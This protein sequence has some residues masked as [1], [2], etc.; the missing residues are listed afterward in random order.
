[1]LACVLSCA[2]SCGGG[3]GAN[4]GSGTTTQPVSTTPALSLSSSTAG[5]SAVAGSANPTPQSIS[6]S[7]GGTGSLTGL[8][9]GTIVYGPGQVGGWLAATLSG[10]TA[11]ATL[12]LTP[13]VS[14]LPVGSYSA[15]IPISSSAAGVINS[16][17]VVSATLTVAAGAA[18]RLVFTTQ[19]AAPTGG[20]ISPA[21]TVAIEDAVGNVV[22]NATPNVTVTAAAN[23]SGATLGGTTTVAAVAGVA[24][25]G[26]LTVS[27]TATGLTLVASVPGLPSATSAAFNVTV[28]AATSISLAAAGQS[29]SFLTSPNF[30][31]ALSVQA[32]SQYLIAVVNTDTSYAQTEGF[33]LAGSPASSVA[34]ARG[35]IASV[36]A[37][38]SRSVRAATGPAFPLAARARAERARQQGRLQ[39]HAAMLEQNR[40]IYAQ[41]GN[42]AAAWAGMRAAG[43]QNAAL[44]AALLPAVGTVGTVNKVYVPNSLDGGCGS[45]D[46]IGARTVAVG[47]HV[48]VLADTSLANWPQAFRPDSSFY[49]TY[50]NEYDQI[51]WPHLLTNIGNPIA[52]DASLSQ[53]GKVTVTITPVL[54][55]LAGLVGGG[56]V[57]AFTNMCDFYPSRSAAIN[58][59]FSNQ[60][61][62]FYS[63]VP[64]SNAD[65][66]PTWEAELRATSAHESKHLVSYADRIIN[67]SPVFEEI[68]LEEGL[69]N[70]SSEIWM[71]NFNQATWLGNATF[72]QTVACELDLGPNAPCDINDDKP[73]AL[74]F[75]H[76]SYLFEYLEI[77][78]VLN[79]EGLGLDAPA[80]YGAGWSIGRWATDQYA[81][82][83]EGPFIKSLINEPLLV[84]LPNMSLHTGATV[85][86]LLTYWNVATAIFQ[87]PNYV[88]ADVR[89]TIPS[90]NFADIFSVGQLDLTC[91]GIPCGLFTDSGSPTYPVQP[92]PLGTAGAFSMA[93]NAVPGTSATFFLLSAPAAGVETLQ[94]LAPGGTALASTSG[95][96]VAILR[97]Q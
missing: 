67:H 11:P 88:A 38:P 20:A 58:S 64:A 25:F 70:E 36:R 66:V 3:G 83:T 16:P 65:D 61:E 42:P 84:G 4:D 79:G 63:F 13:A 73:L 29:V 80:N 94:L 17:Q 59:G 90:F 27:K 95:F 15:S 34:A 87:T 71:R 8:A 55:N 14:A 75:N 50:A 9:A 53:L 23:A 77:E 39:N 74:T 19:P 30:N 46:S 32:G 92:V 85:P 81:I 45:V 48:I 44:S 72:V 40:R 56:T 78:S 93:V 31:G 52:Y 60:T 6:I 54:N 33:S 2:L 96:R 82:G 86:T 43:R 97:V 7:N 41:S 18:T 37:A 22:T 10:T 1:M 68:W 24:T 51:T 21:V 62:M 89:T 47:Q 35:H 49:Q 26:N 57:V 69:A 91:G 76:L 5:F 28:V 12:T